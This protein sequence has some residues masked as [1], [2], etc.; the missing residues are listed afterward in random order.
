MDR[1]I[2]RTNRSRVSLAA[3]LVGGFVGV[4]CRGD[5]EGFVGLSCRGS[6]WRLLSGVSLAFAVGV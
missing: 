5:P 1:L 2:L 6:R 3:V 4:C